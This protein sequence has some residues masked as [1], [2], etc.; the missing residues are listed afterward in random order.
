MSPDLDALFPSPS[1]P[2][3]CWD[4]TPRTLP[5]ITAESTDKL[6][7]LLHSN[8]ENFHIFFN[9][10]GYHNHLTHHVFAAWALGASA[11][12]LQKSYDGHASFQR[13]KLIS[14]EKITEANWTSYLGH[15]N[16]QYYD[17][18]KQFFDEKLS[19]PDGVS[20]TLE[21]FLFSDEA[22][23]GASESSAAGPMM[24]ARFYGGPLHPMIHIGHIEFGIPGMVAEGLALTC[25]SDLRVAP[26]FPP[27]FFSA[28]SQSEQRTSLH[29]FDIVADMLQDNRLTPQK[30]RSLDSSQHPL[31]ETVD[32]VGAIIR[33]YAG[34]W[35]VPVDGDVK[36][37]RSKIEELQWLS[38]I[39]FGV[40]GWRPGHRFRSDFFLCVLHGKLSP[41]TS[42]SLLI[43]CSNDYY[44]PRMHI[45]TSSIFLPSL[46][47][48]LS[49]SSQSALLRGHFSSILLLWISRGRPSLHIAEFMESVTATP[50][51][52]G[53]RPT[54]SA[55]ALSRPSSESNT[56]QL[57]A[58]DNPWL[59]IIQSVMHHPDEHLVKTIRAL[60]HYAQVYGT[61]RIGTFGETRL[62]GAGRLDGTLFVRV[63]GNAMDALG[64]VREGETKGSYDFANLGWDETWN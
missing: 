61:R 29:S 54:P 64:W 47:A 50:S 14:P 19:R 59:N 30:I 24:L 45:L 33:E 18:Y 7:E 1:R 20:K 5:G 27:D 46:A 26:L 51:P 28:S 42:A 34:Q 6:I 16:E 22:N 25:V 21:E 10:Q 35:V 49:P 3:E 58:Y 57:V 39:I 4:Q 63:A 40:C 8:D 12:G 41:S 31:D 60:Q 62:A 17:G 32:T 44:S 53:A 43:P 48:F 13:K 55:D 23:H 15:K 38:T 36:T 56:S 9:S 2:Q 11:I 52:P 37:L